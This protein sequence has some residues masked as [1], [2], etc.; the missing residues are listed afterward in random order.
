MHKFLC[1]HK[2]YVQ[3]NFHVMLKKVQLILVQKKQILR[4]VV[5]CLFLSK[6]GPKKW[7]FAI[8]NLL[9][10]HL[11]LQNGAWI[12]IYSIRM[13]FAECS[14][15]EDLFQFL[16]LTWSYFR[17]L[18]F[19]RNNIARFLFENEKYEI[20]AGRNQLASTIASKACNFWLAKLTFWKRLLISSVGIQYSDLDLR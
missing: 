19:S 18:L 15:T 14:V 1:W 8:S 7:V 17:S 9:K 10:K 13:V 12:L 2:N 4:R 16:S 6:S 5:E 20:Q 3:K 11:F